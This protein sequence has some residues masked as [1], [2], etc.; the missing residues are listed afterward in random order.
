MK[1]RI[2]KFGVIVS[3]GA[4]LISSS[5]AIAEETM[6]APT[7]FDTSRDNAYLLRFQDGDAITVNTSGYKVPTIQTDSN[8]TTLGRYR[9]VLPVCDMAI[10]FGCIQSVELRNSLDGPWEVLTPG[11]KFWNAEIAAT[12]TSIEGVETSHRWSTWS[13]EQSSGLP[14]SGKVQLFESSLH[15]HGGGNTYVVKA[16]MSGTEKN[17]GTYTSNKFG[18]SVIPV[19][20][21]SYDPTTTSSRE[22][23]AVR[24][25]RFPKSLEV[26]VT[27]RLGSLFAQ[28]DGW[29][30]GRVGDAQLN[31]NK[32]DQTLVVSGKP[33]TSPVQNGYMPFPVPP[34]FK[35]SFLTGPSDKTGKLPSYVYS[36]SNSR[37]LNNWLKLKDY[38]IPKAIYESEVWQ[39]D[40]NSKASYGVDGDFKACLNN[41]SG[42]LGLI[43]TNATA[44]ETNPPKWNKSDSTL[45]YKVAGPELLSD[46]KKN[47][48]NYLLAIRTDVASCLW[49]SDLKNSKAT[50]EVTN[51][52]GS[53]GV[54]VAT[55]TI[56]QRNGWLYFSASGFHFSA[57]TIKVKLTPQKETK[58]TCLKGKA[59]KVVTGANPKCPAGYKKS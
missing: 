1:S 47:L 10:K 28:L 11:E 4:L 39:I 3:L 54:Q 24:N 20:V 40:V 50:V 7:N 38:L 45:T 49:K 2:L 48:G 53:S 15:G 21:L 35:D 22:I 27:V 5:S 6:P 14:P 34:Q 17:L 33:S 41:K 9:A 29:F 55:T 52:D 12:S 16:L 57:P 18:L 36:P 19:K 37:S 23:R 59:T 26:R 56:S 32:V 44:Y 58:I 8:T 46:G 25:Y 42:I 13:G 30:F 31:M 43:T 51:G